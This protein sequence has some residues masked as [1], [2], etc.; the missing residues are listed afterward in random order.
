MHTRGS[1]ARR[2]MSH[3]SSTRTHPFART[4]AT[5]YSPLINTLPT[6]VTTHDAQ[7]TTHNSRLTTHDSLQAARACSSHSR[8]S[9]SS[10]PCAAASPLTTRAPPTK[11][12]PK[13]KPNPNHNPDPS[14]GPTQEFELGGMWW[15]LRFW[16]RSLNPSP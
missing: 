7:L 9:P 5:Y 6:R 8:T 14:P 12:K 10:S 16:R 1:C 15:T 4:N 13:P 11:P 2:W 3:P